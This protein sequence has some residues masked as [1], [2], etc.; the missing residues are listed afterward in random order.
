M[1]VV[2]GCG[3]VPPD[4]LQVKVQHRRSSGKLLV[5]TE[6]VAVDNSYNMSS[7]PLVTSSL[8][9]PSPAAPDP[10]LNLTFDLTLS[11]RERE[12]RGQLVPPYHHSAG[13]K[14]A[15]LQVSP[16][17]ISSSPQQRPRAVLVTDMSW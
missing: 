17:I 16:S 12:E 14:T 3:H 4:Q 9:T 8:P 10:T 1:G 5:S 11:E 6:V 13:K 2:E 15:L 7:V